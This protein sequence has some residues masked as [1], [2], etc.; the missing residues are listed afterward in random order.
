MKKHKAPGF[1]GIVTEML[2]ATWEIGLDWLT[3]LSHYERRM[4]T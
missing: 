2:Q 3:E 4:Y 1:F